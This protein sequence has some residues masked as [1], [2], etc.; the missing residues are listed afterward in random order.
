MRMG[1]L[2]TR[3][4]YG[5]QHNDRQQGKR[6]G[7]RV[8]GALSSRQTNECGSTSADVSLRGQSPWCRILSYIDGPYACAAVQCVDLTV[9]HLIDISL[10]RMGHIFLV[11]PI[12]IRR[13]VRR[14]GRKSAL[15]QSYLYIQ[16]DKGPRT[17]RSFLI[18]CMLLIKLQK[19][20]SG[21]EVH[22][23]CK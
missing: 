12:A 23:P 22:H 6:I 7:C 1:S 4:C 13:S 18:L 14:P 21:K 19:N 20:S 8:F 9:G 5:T 17:G 15:L 3:Q 11:N 10:R 2:S 16:D